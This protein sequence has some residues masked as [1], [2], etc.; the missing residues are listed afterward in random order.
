MVLICA[1][2]IIAPQNKNILGSELNR[3]TYIVDGNSMNPTLKSGD[4]VGVTSDPWKQGDMVIVETQV[5]KVIKRLIG[6]ELIGDNKKNSAVFSVDDVKILGKA[7]K[8]NP[9]IFTGN[10]PKVFALTEEYIYGKDSA[11]Q[12][13]KAAESLI[14]LGTITSDTYT[15][16]VDGKKIFGFDSTNV[17]VYQTT[18]TIASGTQGTTKK[19]VISPDGK[20]RYGLNSSKVIVYQ[21]T[22]SI[23]ETPFISNM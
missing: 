12:Y 13:V 21:D 23:S 17:L 19:S 1:L 11:G 4:V 9:E 18:S 2:G 20:K 22:S 6:T 10:L 5:G 15:L 7:E 16:S 3:G 14:P 8:L